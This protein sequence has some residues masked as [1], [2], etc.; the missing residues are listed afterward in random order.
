MRSLLFALAISGIL[1]SCR[2]QPAQR[3]AQIGQSTAP[4]PPDPTAPLATDEKQT[5]PSVSVPISDQPGRVG[6]PSSPGP[7]GSP[8]PPVQDPGDLPTP[9]TSTPD[10]GVWSPPPDAP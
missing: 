7:T 3:G 6:S 8:I 10:A 2:T 1:A 5:G 4:L 9:P